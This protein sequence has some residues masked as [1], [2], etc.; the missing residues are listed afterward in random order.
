MAHKYDRGD[1]L[2]HGVANYFW[3]LFVGSIEGSIGSLAVPTSARMINDSLDDNI[4]AALEKDG[5]TL[6]KL[7]IAMYHGTRLVTRVGIHATMMYQMVN[8]LGDGHG[9]SAGL[10]IVPNVI[11][12]GYEL[13]RCGRSVESQ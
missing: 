6:N 8:D 4:D 1:L 11:S 5:D 7:G 10:L 12:A 9:V 3:G 13:Y 2:V